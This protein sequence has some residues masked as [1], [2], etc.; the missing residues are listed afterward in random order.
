VAPSPTGA[1]YVVIDHAGAPPGAKL[2]I[3]AEWEEYGRMRWTALKVDAAGRQLA[4]LRVT[5]LDRGTHA[6]MTIEPLD[7]VDRVI[8]VG[9]LVGSDGSAER[10][11]DPDDGVWER[12]GW[13]LTVQ[14]E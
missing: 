9:T 14:A 5:S 6:A 8:V 1:S 13:L 11:F 3:E 2:R 10:P 12:H 4:D 7:G